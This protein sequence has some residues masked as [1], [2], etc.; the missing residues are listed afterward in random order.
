MGF[1]ARG[2]GT[3]LRGAPRVRA[4]SMALAECDFTQ[5]PLGACSDFGADFIQN[6]LGTCVGFGADF[7]QNSLGT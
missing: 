2:S 1:A 4:H 3:G 5:N 6:S 7:I